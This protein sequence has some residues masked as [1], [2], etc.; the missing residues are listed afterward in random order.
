MEVRNFGWVIN[1]STFLIG[2][3]LYLT[4]PRCL[5]HLISNQVAIKAGSIEREATSSS[6][7]LLAM[8]SN[9]LLCALLFLLAVGQTDAGP[10]LY[11]GCVAS[12]LFL[13]TMVSIF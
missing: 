10:I 7:V 2:N 13:L 8:R 12:E 1:Y 4:F 6:R 5:S 11:G 9:Q 3:N